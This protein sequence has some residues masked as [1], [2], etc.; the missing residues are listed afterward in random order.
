MRWYRG[1]EEGD[2]SSPL[3]YMIGLYIVVLVLLGSSI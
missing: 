3:G 2:A 1:D